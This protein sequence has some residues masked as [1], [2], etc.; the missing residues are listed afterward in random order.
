MANQ[1]EISLPNV[2]LF[3]HN[4]NYNNGLTIV[5]SDCFIMYDV[6]LISLGSSEVVRKVVC[7]FIFLKGCDP[8]PTEPKWIEGT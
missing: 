5:R 7:R 8:H 1:D 3:T 2:W 6:M 4:M